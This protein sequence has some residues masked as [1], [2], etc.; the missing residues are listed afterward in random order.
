MKFYRDLAKEAWGLMD[1]KPQRPYAL[2][3]YLF[4]GRLTAPARPQGHGLCLLERERRHSHPGQ[5]GLARAPHQEERRARGPHQGA[6]RRTGQ[7]RH[8]GRGVPYALR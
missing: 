5:P 2:P 6:G 4:Q 8:H 7:H 3:R 1:Y